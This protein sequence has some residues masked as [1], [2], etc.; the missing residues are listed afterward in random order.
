MSKIT[1][2]QV[3]Y[4]DKLKEL[5]MIRSCVFHKEQG[6]DPALEFD[7]NDDKC[8]H[9]LAYLDDEPVG[10]TRIRYLNQDTAKI[11][12][13]AVLLMARGQGIGSQLV[14]QAIKI[15]EEKRTYK[16]IIIHAQ[17]YIQSLYE[18]LGFQPIGDRFL[19]GDIIHIK[20]VKHINE[21]DN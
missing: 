7:G 14:K 15:I 13:L 11:E 9:L 5:K 3:K 18:K 2:K 4:Q 16:E 1:I 8:H 12:R 20:M 21:L 17:I 19:E 10:T 6:V